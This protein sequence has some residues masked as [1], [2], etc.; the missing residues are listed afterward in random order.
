[1]SEIRV[2][3]HSGRAHMGADELGRK[4]RGGDGK[5]AETGREE[6]IGGGRGERGE[7]RRRGAPL[8]VNV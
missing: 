3:K 5:A 7:E 1:M 4:G 8:A 6:G 2:H